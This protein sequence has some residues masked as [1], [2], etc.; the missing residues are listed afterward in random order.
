MVLCLKL[1]G[2]L[3]ACVPGSG[4]CHG[5][6]VWCGGEPWHTYLA[7]ECALLKASLSGDLVPEKQGRC[8]HSRS[9]ITC[10]VTCVCAH[11]CAHVCAHTCICAHVCAHVY[12]CVH[13]CARVCMFMCV[14][15]D[16]CVLVCVLTHVCSLVYSYVCVC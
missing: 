8:W 13:V 7:L 5:E 11:M 15:A 9:L 4:R 14:C 12:V 2:C 6:G 16:V 1:F 3:G 10:V